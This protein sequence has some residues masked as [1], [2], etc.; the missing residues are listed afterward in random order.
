MSWTKRQFVEA[1]FEEI[2]LAGYVFD[3]QPEQLN[4]AL[5]RLDAMMA[6]WNNMGIRISYPLPSSPESGSLDQETNVPDRANEAIYTN[7]AIKLAGTVGKQVSQDTRNT[8]KKG[9]DGLLMEA[10]QPIPLQ[11][12]STMPLGAGN[13]TAGG[14]SKYFPKP[15]DPLT[16]GLD[17]T[18]DF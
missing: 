4:M 12:P 1:A 11:Y 15:T 16:A 9:Y 8:A 2:G 14:Y 5:R 7:L 17:T 10:A 6:T 3:L 18:L 13:K